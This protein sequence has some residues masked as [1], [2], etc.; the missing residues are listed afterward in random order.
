MV[1]PIWFIMF[2]IHLYCAFVYFVVSLRRR[3]CFFSLFIRNDD[4]ISKK[5]THKNDQEIWNWESKRKIK[6]NWNE[7]ERKQSKNEVITHEQELFRIEHW[8]CVN[9]VRGLRCMC[10]TYE[11]MRPVWVWARLEYSR[12]MF[13][14]DR[15]SCRSLL[16]TLGVFSQVGLSERELEA[17]RGRKRA[18]QAICIGKEKEEGREIKQKNYSNKAI[19]LENRRTPCVM[20]E[21]MQ[22]YNF[23]VF[24]AM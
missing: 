11:C 23:L 7:W 17:K 21:S 12:K 16:H 1:I 3:R 24:S 9:S 22:L 2:T 5:N 19:T 20:R 8:N 13:A 6:I 18:R 14:T 4:G 15:S 10:Y